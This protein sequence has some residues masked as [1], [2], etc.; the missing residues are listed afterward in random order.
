MMAA[1]EAET[2][3]PVDL[4][5]N[6]VAVVGQPDK[7]ELKNSSSTVSTAASIEDLKGS[8]VPT[9]RA[10]LF[11]QGGTLPSA[12]CLC[13]AALGAGILS[14]A[15]HCAD[16]GFVYQLVAMIVGALLSL[17]SISMIADASISTKCWSY[18][19]ICEDLFHPAMSFATGLINVCNCLG[20]AAAYLIVC[21]QVFQ[22]LSG[23]DEMARKLFVV[24]IGVLVCAPMALA[25][26]LGFMRHLAALSVGALLL[27]VVA[28]IWFL[29]EHGPDE[30]VTPQ[31]FFAGSGMATVFTYMNAVNNIIFAY[32]NQFN[33]PQLTGE[34]KP[35]PSVKKMSHVSLMS[36]GLSFL[37]YAGVS[38]FGVLAFGIGENQ[39][40]SLILDLYP[41]RGNVLVFM[42]LAAVMFS[43]LTCFQFHVYPIRQFA[44]FAIRKFRG[45]GAEDESTDAVYYGKSLTRWLD[46]ASALA[47]VSVIIL[48][49]V[50]IT[51]LR[52]ILDF[53]GA[54]ASAYT[55]YVVPP[56]WIIQVRRR[57]EGF[58]WRNRVVMGCLAFFSLGIFLFIFGTYAA[59][60]DA[61]GN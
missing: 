15:A 22:V 57:Q 19:D 11:R 41:E 30:S 60:R 44:A 12:I 40:D 59:V 33:V 31:N 23:A 28:V 16:V 27:L 38:V 21:G 54:F 53:I 45:R 61:V 2:K 46:I 8:D 32:N 34:L 58:T 14:M 37:L 36:T 26:H 52:T 17:V 18:E 24:A 43:V 3:V 48:I 1:V 56:L 49:A 5:A 50:V 25:E 20:A 39:K 42:S 13:K 29:G 10:K 4:E 6:C 47:A 35:V 7:P 51:S 9:A 55:S